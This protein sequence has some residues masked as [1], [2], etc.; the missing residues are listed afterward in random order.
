[1]P[2]SYID[3]FSC[4]DS[5]LHSLDKYQLIILYNSFKVLLGE[6]YWGFCI[7]IHEEYWLLVYLW[8]L[9]LWCCGTSGILVWIMKC[10]LETFLKKWYRFVWCP[11]FI[12]VLV[13]WDFFFQLVNLKFYQCC[14]SSKAP[15]FYFTSFLYCFW[16]ICFTCFCSSLLFSLFCQLWV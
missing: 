4:L 3:W 11:L 15:N 13:I 10:F 16:C 14:W 7:C 12:S 5:F 6:V 2:G 9:W 8:Y 1:M